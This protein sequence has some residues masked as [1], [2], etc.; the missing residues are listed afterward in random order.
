MI[1]EI[2]ARADTTGGMLVRVSFSGLNLCIGGVRLQLPVFAVKWAPS[3]IYFV[4]SST[5]GPPTSGL[6][7]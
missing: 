7:K 1:N 4:E 2:L 5:C 6:V 3:N